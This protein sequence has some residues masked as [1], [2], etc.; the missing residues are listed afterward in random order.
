MSSTQPEATADGFAGPL[1]V[2]RRIRGSKPPPPP[3][4]RC[5]LCAEAIATEHSHVVNLESRA[6]LCACRA[7]HLLFSHEQPGLVYR[8]VRER[9]LSFPAFKLTRQQWD[10][11]CIPVGLAFFFRNSRLRRTVACYPGPAGAAECELPLGAWDAIV[12]VNPTL[13]EAAPDIE[14]ILVRSRASAFVCYLVPIDACYE[15]VGHLRRLWRGFDGGQEAHRRLD[16]FFDT[17]ERRGTPVAEA[18][19]EP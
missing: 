7:C 1:A 15:L 10:D 13:A 17:V 3:G 9:Y 4:E 18:V 6:L 12:A 11:L 2:L 19:T 8:A 5:E 14:A 16:E